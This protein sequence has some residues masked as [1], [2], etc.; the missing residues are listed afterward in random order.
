VATATIAP[1]ASVNT[2][3]YPIINT[4]VYGFSGTLGA[5]IVVAVLTLAL[6][7]VLAVVQRTVT[8]KGIKIRGGAAPGRGKFFAI[9]TPREGQVT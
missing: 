3:G 6:D 1:L 4:N 8:P 2:L 7:G 5:A 9:R